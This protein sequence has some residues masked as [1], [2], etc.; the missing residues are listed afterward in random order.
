[1]SKQNGVSIKNNLIEDKM[2]VGDI[3]GRIEATGGFLQIPQAQIE[4]SNGV[5]TQTPG[6]TGNDIIY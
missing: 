6:W 2:N 4:L 5:L 3:A 1:L